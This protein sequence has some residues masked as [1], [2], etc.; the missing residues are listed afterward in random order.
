M[1]KSEIYDALR[2][3]LQMNERKNISYSSKFHSF[4]SRGKESNLIFLL[5]F[6]NTI[7]NFHR[8]CVSIRDKRRRKKNLIN[9]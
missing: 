3:S 5:K 4:R 7:T 9:L 2:Y 1:C 8:K 6:F